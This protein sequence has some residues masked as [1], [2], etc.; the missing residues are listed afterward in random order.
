MK[1]G[2]FHYPLFHHPQ[3]P[4]SQFALSISI[5]KNIRELRHIMSPALLLQSQSSMFFFHNLPEHRTYLSLQQELNKQMQKA[6]E[7]AS[8]FLSPHF[9]TTN[10]LQG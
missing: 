5:H 10:I 7:S 8:F 3:D 6:A 1:Y 9:N 4:P 2:L